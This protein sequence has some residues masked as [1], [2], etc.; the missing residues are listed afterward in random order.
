MIWVAASWP[1]KIWLQGFNQPR[2]K[3]L[4]SFFVRCQF[5][6]SLSSDA[7]HWP[8]GLSQYSSHRLVGVRLSLNGEEEWMSSVTILYFSGMIAEIASLHRC[9]LGRDWE[10]SWRS[11]YPPKDDWV[12]FAWRRFI[13]AF[14]C[15]WFFFF[16]LHERVWEMSPGLLTTTWCGKSA[17]SFSLKSCFHWVVIYLVL[18]RLWAKSWN[19]G[20]I[21]SRP[22][23]TSR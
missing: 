8:G 1:R 23:L 3:Q 12:S 20:M 6:R 16:F 17:W 4:Y 22:E 14:Y 2:R 11:D 15:V 7:I 21:Y 10:E 5:S 18:I 19:S 9:V 13:D